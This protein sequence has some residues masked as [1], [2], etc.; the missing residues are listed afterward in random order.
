MTDDKC[1][2]GGKDCVSKATHVCA[3]CKLHVCAQCSLNVPERPFEGG[4]RRI[5]DLCRK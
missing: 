5:C 4:V 3:V 1:S 2:V